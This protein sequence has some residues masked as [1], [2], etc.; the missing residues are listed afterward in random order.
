MEGVVDWV[1]N[2]VF[3]LLFL[4]LALSLL[5]AGK[6]EKYVRLFAGMVFVLA[7]VRPFT[8]SLRLEEKL[9][10]YMEQ[11]SFQNEAADFEREL[12]GMEER[13]MEELTSKYEETV[14]EQVGEMAREAGVEPERVEVEIDGDRESERFGMVTEVAVVAAGK[15]KTETEPQK[16]SLEGSRISVEAVREVEPVEIGIGK[17][18]GKAGQ[19]TAGGDVGQEGVLADLPEIT[20]SERKTAPAPAPDGGTASKSGPDDGERN[21]SKPENAPASSGNAAVTARQE[22][23]TAP[24]GAETAPKQNL[25]SAGESKVSADLRRRIAEYYHLEEGHVEIQLE[26]E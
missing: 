14:A 3:Y 24:E 8:V 16:T 5:P 13:R 23:E 20:E 18:K 2:L 22:T 25:D 21:G 10:G 12:M 19:E 9:A 4:T 17:E 26:H 1:K 11:V 15:G 6:Y 7:A